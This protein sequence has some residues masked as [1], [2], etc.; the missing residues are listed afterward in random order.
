MID[1]NNESDHMVDEKRLVA[2]ARF[3]LDALHIHPDAELS[4]VLV[5]EDT[6]AAYHEKFLS[7]PGPTDV[8]SFPMDE[9]TPPRPGAE[10]PLGVLGDIMLC[11]TVTDRQ[12]A[13][14]GRSPIQEMEH[15][16]IH[17]LLHLLGF[18]HADPADKAIMFSLNDQ[19]IQSWT[20][21]RGKQVR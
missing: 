6:I 21:Y 20:Q 9:L 7:E 3:A 2:L 4:I 10:P 19:L 15:L 8:L 18:D 5:D 17:G 16:L 1:I 14:M 12:A 11:P 13:Q